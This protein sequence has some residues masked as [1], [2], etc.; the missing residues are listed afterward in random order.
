MRNDA[1]LGLKYALFGAKSTD[2]SAPHP[3]FQTLFEKMGGGLTLLRISTSNSARTAPRYQPSPDALEQHSAISPRQPSP[4]CANLSQ[5]NL[6][7][8]RRQE[9]QVKP[10]GATMELKFV[11][12]ATTE[13]DQ[14]DL[15]EMAAEIWRVLASTYRSGTDRLHDRAVPEPKRHPAR[16]GA[17]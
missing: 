8:Q 4:R 9:R 15:A 2:A 3:F 12:V 17:S 11:P 13:Q 10:L 16:H 14:R 5:T 6:H 1:D 7:A